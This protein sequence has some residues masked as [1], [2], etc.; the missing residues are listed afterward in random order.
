MALVLAG[1]GRS[2]SL[3][4]ADAFPAPVPPATRDDPATTPQLEAVPERDTA[5]LAASEPSA[6][7]DLLAP[8]LEALRGTVA[9]ARE[10][11]RISIYDDVLILGFRR[12]G[13]VGRSASAGYFPDGRMN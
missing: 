6:D 13:E 3:P 5:G 11:D 10:F 7:T 12:P 2:V 9:G 4:D 8:G 1:C